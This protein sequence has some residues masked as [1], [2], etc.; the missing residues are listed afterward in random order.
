VEV[1]ALQY[2]QLLVDRALLGRERGA[3]RLPS[4]TSWAVNPENM[5]PIQPSISGRPESKTAAIYDVLSS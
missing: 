4:A 3:V 1:L 2:L 5:R